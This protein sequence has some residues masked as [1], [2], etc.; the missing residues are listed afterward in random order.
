MCLPSS[1]TILPASNDFSST[2]FLLRITVNVALSPFAAPTI[3][4]RFSISFSILKASSLT[5]F[6]SRSVFVAIKFTPLIFFALAI[7]SPFRFPAFALRSCSISF[8]KEAFS[9]CSAA[10]DSAGFLVG[11]FKTALISSKFFDCSVKKSL[12]ASLVI[13]SIRRIPD[14]TA[15]SLV[16]LKCQMSPVFFT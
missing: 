4:K 11:F 13:A 14:A 2:R 1:L 5:D 8:F 9:S 12:T 15:L 10:I 7:K 3:K 16:I 6:A